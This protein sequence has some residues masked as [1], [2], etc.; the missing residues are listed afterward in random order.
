MK[1]N[2][3]QIAAAAAL[4]GV[5]SIAC[6]TANPITQPANPISNYSTGTT[7]IYLA[8]SSAVD[9][10]L[11]K[12]IANSCV[13]N[14]LDSYR[15]DAGGKTYYLWTCETDGLGQHFTGFANS[16][17]AIHKNTNSSSDGV[18]LVVDTPPAAAFLQVNDIAS[19]SSCALSTV[20]STTTISAYNRYV[21]GTT[22]GTAGV[23][24]LS[25]TATFGFSDSEPAQYNV[26]KIAQVT[27]AYPFSVI[28]GVAVTKSLRDAL[29]TQQGLVLGSEAL[30][31]VPNLTSPQIQAIFTGRDTALS[32]AFGLPTTTSDNKVYLVRRSGG[33]GTTRSFD[34]RQIGDICNASLQG[35]TAGTTLVTSTISTQCTTTALGG[36]QKLQAGTSDDLAAC[37]SSYET[38]SAYGIGYLTT[39]Y[40]PTAGDG[41]RW[42]KI[43]GY[44][45]SLKNVADGKYKMWSELSL[46]YNTTAGIAA[47]NLAFYNTLKAASANAVFMGEVVKNLPQVTSGLWTG[48]IIGAF[49]NT[50][51]QAG[52]GLP[53]AAVLPVAGRTD[54]ALLSNPANALTRATTTGYNLCAPTYAAP[55]YVAN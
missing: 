30:A 28:Q 43:D 13:D 9:L 41:Y 52:W 31:D 49:P 12:F 4:L 25:T 21:C 33:S 34:A 54:S 5:S 26:A 48:G 16:K 27:A 15:S 11:E 42:V 29:Q 19:T 8:G 37:L 45:P 46:N 20:A 7:D 32:T 44:T 3:T 2:L 35:I 55:G 17:I 18:N 1:F 10:A 14:S 38:N 47:D 23:G 24:S 36:V 39:D 50:K 22:I 51:N 6:A 40:T 53:V